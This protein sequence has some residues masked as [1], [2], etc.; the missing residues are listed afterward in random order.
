MSSWSSHPAASLPVGELDGGLKGRITL[1]NREEE[2]PSVADP[3]LA[4]VL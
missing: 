1:D 4:G 2:R 3:L